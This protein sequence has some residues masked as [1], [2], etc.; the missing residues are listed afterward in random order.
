MGEL[1]FLL[2]LA[3]VWAIIH[4]CSSFSNMV[5]TSLSGTIT[6]G[7]VGLHSSARSRPKSQNCFH[8]SVR[9]LR[10]ASARMQAA[11]LPELDQID[12]VALTHHYIPVAA[13]VILHV[14][15]A[16]NSGNSNADNDSPAICL[17]HGFP[18][19]WLGWRRQLPLLA[20]A[21]YRVICPDLRGYAKSSKPQGIERYSEVR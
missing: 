10:I 1:R 9:K 8:P 5:V 13:D 15:E 4:P 20:Q 7:S 3:N 11:S 16:R 18:D 6:K 14:V 21:G 17:L 2:R 19:F 12:G